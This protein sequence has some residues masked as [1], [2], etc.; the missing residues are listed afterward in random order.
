MPEVQTIPK[1]GRD[2][3]SLFQTA[4]GSWHIPSI[5]MAS[6]WV[7]G[8]LLTGIFMY[9][10]LS[11]NRNDR[12]RAF[13]KERQSAVSSAELAK[14]VADADKEAAAAR[15]LAEK[16][17]IA[18]APRRLSE[19]NISAIKSVMQIYAKRPKIAIWFR[20]DDAE[21]FDFAM[22]FNELFH[23]LGYDTNWA[24][25]MAVTLPPG[26]TLNTAYADSSVVEL[27]RAVLRAA[28]FPFQEATVRMA[29]GDPPSRDALLIFGSKP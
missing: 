18:H 26:I 2:M 22:Q 9:A 13:D 20:G 15:E 27:M 25:M 29:A 17:R 5:L 19:A 28:G 3:I 4:Q 1:I 10:N 11:V 21:A 7:I 12:L 24:Q 8:T 14:R 16:L 23:S 6:S